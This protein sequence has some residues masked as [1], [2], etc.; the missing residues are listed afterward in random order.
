MTGDVNNPFK[1]L[2][3]WFSLAKAEEKM[4][5]HPAMTLTTVNPKTLQPTIRYV[6][7]TELSQQKGICFFTNIQSKKALEIGQN[8]RVST[9]FFWPSLKRGIFIQGRA[10]R[11]TE[12]EDTHFFVNR[13]I[14]SQLGFSVP[15]QTQV[16]T[17][18]QKREMVSKIEQKP[19]KLLKN[20]KICSF[21]MIFLDG[22]NEEYRRRIEERGV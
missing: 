5:E 16:I 2:L 19:Q 6:I 10:F 11:A 17:E 9:E 15:R 12:E 20:S 7:M 8:S 18:H 22:E 14:K 1:T 4:K 21:L 13:P 3:E